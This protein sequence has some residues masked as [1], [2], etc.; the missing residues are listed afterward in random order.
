MKKINILLA[1]LLLICFTGC[2]D[3]LETESK[4][5]LT[6]DNFYKTE[7]EVM[8]GLYAAMDDVQGRLL[9]VFSYASL[10]SDE[11]ETGGGIGEGVYKY[12]YDNF[13]YDV[14]TSPAWWNEWDYGLYNGV[15]SCN[16][17]IGKLNGS[18]LN[19]TFVKSIDAEA[20]FYRALFYFYLFMGYEQ[21]PLIKQH[22]STS[23]IYSVKKGTR[24]EIYDFMLSD[25]TDEV[26][27]HLP[28]KAN[29]DNGRIS[30]DAARVL[31]AKIILFHRDKT[32]YAEALSIMKEIIT[33]NRYS[34]ISDYS[35]IWLKSGEYGSESIYEV[36]FAGDNTS[37]GNPLAR[38]LSGRSVKDPRSA[39]QGGL[40]E[41][42]GQNTMPSIIYNMFK[43]GDTRREGTVIVYVD[44]KTKVSNLVTAGQLPAG[45]AFT[46]SEQQENYEGLG[47]YKYHARKESSTAINP[48]YNY[49]N[50]FRFYRYADVLL[51]A[52]ELQAR[53][54]SVDS[55][56]QGWF[57]QIR[58]RAFQDQLHRIDLTSKSQ[59]D[60]LN[61]IFEE[62]GYEFIDEMQ[63]WFDI[64]RFDKG[65]E[66]LSSKG[67]TEKH[68][69]YPISQ[70]EIDK[71]KGALDQNPGWK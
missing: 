46:I 36:G 42:W 19:P 71:S 4:T 45:S 57:N 66:I 65:Q 49:S 64:M 9:E 69:Y 5:S 41:G 27:T 14:T 26:I 51:L 53:I 43:P 10:M 58:D 47:H 29:T 67:W 48:L 28:D 22:M 25:L 3:F 12:K 62:R 6:E 35:K 39:E 7:G 32:R 40:E 33:G 31:K 15:T 1:T 16:I 17:L 68:R 60:A 24:D 21:F 37:E 34:L 38:S 59:S 13:T 70:N 11:S 61:I 30:K 55:E 63:R 56:G 44:E 2:D 18:S 52:V 20:R 50:T 23:E 54:G 8:M